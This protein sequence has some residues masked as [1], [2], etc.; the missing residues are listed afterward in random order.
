MAACRH[1][2]SCLREAHEPSHRLCIE[3]ALLQVPRQ[4]GRILQRQ[5]HTL[6]CN[7]NTMLEG[8]PFK[9]R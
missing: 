8:L 7:A 2:R 9:S 6:A 4:H 3:T 1:S 5:H